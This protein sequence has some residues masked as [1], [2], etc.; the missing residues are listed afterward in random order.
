MG[1]SSE[2]FQFINT[3][4][5]NTAI[6]TTEDFYNLIIN[7]ITIDIKDAFIFIVKNNTNQNQYKGVMAVFRKS[8]SNLSSNDRWYVREANTTITTGSNFNFY[9]DQG[10]TMDIYK[11]MG[12]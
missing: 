8:T 4:A 6:E 5:I 1:I 2:Q 3:I 11:I 12:V 9:I 7:N 10:A